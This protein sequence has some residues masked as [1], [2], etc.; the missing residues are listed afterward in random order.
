[1]L[2]TYRRTLPLSLSLLPSPFLSPSLVFCEIVSRQRAKSHLRCNNKC[3]TKSIKIISCKNCQWQRRHLATANRIIHIRGICC[4]HRC[5]CCRIA[6]PT[7]THTHNS[8]S[9]S[10]PGRCHHRCCFTFPVINIHLK[11]NRGTLASRVWQGRRE[12]QGGRGTVLCEWHLANCRMRR[13]KLEF[14]KL[15]AR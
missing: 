10:L 12:I 4:R 1:M 11:N 5:H 13:G 3:Y 7:H 15:C 8:L 9:L 2:S 14:S 6:L